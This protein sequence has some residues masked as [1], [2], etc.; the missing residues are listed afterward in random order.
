MDE[1]I[2]DYSSGALHPADLNPALTKALNKILQVSILKS[3]Y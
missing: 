1:V 3:T 2:A